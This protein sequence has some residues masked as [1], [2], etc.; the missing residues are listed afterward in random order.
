[1]F[2]SFGNVFSSLQPDVQA[3][4]TVRTEF[5]LLIKSDEKQNSRSAVILNN[6][7]FFITVCFIGFRLLAKSKRGFKIYSIV[8]P[9]YFEN[10]IFATSAI[11]VPA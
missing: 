7:F 4:F 10:K 8:E 3:R 1:L 9:I 11:P 6:K 2:V 5:S